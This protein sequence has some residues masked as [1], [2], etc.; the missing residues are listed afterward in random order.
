MRVIF[1]ICI[2][3]LLMPVSGLACDVDG[4]EA[5]SEHDVRTM[6]QVLPEREI[7]E[8][9][10][11]TG[12]N[13]PPFTDASWPQ[14]GMLTELVTT[15][16]SVSPD[17]VSFSVAWQENWSDDLAPRLISKDF[18]MGFPW[19]R[20]DCENFSS[21]HQSC[22]A[23]HF[24]DSLID[25]AILLFVSS[26]SPMAFDQ[27]SDIFG[28]KICRPA[29]FYTHDLDR[30]GRRWISNGHIV[31]EQAATPEA[32]FALLSKGLVD[33]VAMNEF[34]GA[35]TV[36]HMGLGDSVIALERPISIE[37]LHVVISKSHWRGTSHMYRF[38]A[39]LRALK[40]SPDYGEIVN[41][42]LSFFKEHLER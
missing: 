17:P 22:A 10:L 20:P 24:S 16:L 11:I 21:D 41:R 1:A 3:I 31:L 28:H 13:F 36:F 26:E 2:A 5:C 4:D 7:A 9:S 23:F 40:D 19:F 29:G 6:K 42:H 27:D 39:G 18:D 34:L 15:A 8:I 37:G 38:N 14:Q 35:R 33:A 25:L 12:S 30:A 32:C